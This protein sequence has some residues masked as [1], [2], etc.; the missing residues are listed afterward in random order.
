MDQRKFKE[1]S[2]FRREGRRAR[3]GTIRVKITTRRI[4][5][6]PAVLPNILHMKVRK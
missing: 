5:Q 2:L 1:L 4:K 6:N 3:E